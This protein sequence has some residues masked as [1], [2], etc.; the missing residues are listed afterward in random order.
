MF[1]WAITYSIGIATA[2]RNADAAAS[3]RGPIPRQK[4]IASTGAMNKAERHA[5]MKLSGRARAIA[6][7]IA[8]RSGIG[9][10]AAGTS[11]SEET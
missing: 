11:S 9:V 10:R 3:G 1:G 7:R 6:A 2:I 8:R 5:K 4:T